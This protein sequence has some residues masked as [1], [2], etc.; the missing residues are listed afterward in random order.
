ML[1]AFINKLHTTDPDL[2][3]AHN[4]C[5]SVIE[6]LLNRIGI[7]KINH[8]SRIGR[9]KRN[10]I[11]QRKND[12]SISSWVPRQVSCGRLLVDTFLT[13]KE[14]VRETNYELRYLCIQQLGDKA[15]DDLKEYDDE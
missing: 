10:T 6:I 8:W 1:E 11:P 5:G 4:L 12:G 3:I 9:M 7:L 2:I 14:L 13:A 15:K